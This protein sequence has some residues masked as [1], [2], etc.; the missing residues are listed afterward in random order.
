MANDKLVTGSETPEDLGGS[1]I[2]HDVEASKADGI[3]RVEKVYRY[4][5]RAYPL[6]F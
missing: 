2:F 4:V 3:E 1:K 5:E 6:A